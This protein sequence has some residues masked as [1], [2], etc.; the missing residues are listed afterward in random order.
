MSRF[1]SIAALLLVGGPLALACSRSEA[2]QK[3]PE[4]PP[5]APAPMPKPPAAP[6][7]APGAATAPAPFRITSI[8]L[9]T[10]VG[11]DKKVTS[12]ATTFAPTDTIYASVASDGTALSVTLAV[13]WAYQ[14]GQTVSTG[15]QTLAPTGPTATE[16]HISKPSGWPA[17][18]YRVEVSADGVPGPGKD[19]EVK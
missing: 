3:P 9:G 1:R 12:P 15:V 10:A 6:A 18:R 5:M 16:F 2:P 4:P 8:D 19:F 13:R 17:G 7:P 14:D 11:P